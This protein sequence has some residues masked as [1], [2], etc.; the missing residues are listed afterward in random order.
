MVPQSIIVFGATGQ[1]GTDLVEVLRHENNFEV[2]A[3]SHQ[4]ADCTDREAVRRMFAQVRPDIVVNC[5]AFVRVDECEERVDDAFRVNAVG[6]FNVAKACAEIEALCVFISTDYVFD[7]AKDSAYG[8]SDA[9]NPI[10]VYGASKLAG[11][12]LTRQAARRCLIVRTASLFGKTGARGKGGNFVETIIKKAKAHEPIKVVNDITMSPTY[13]RDA[14]NGL[15][16]LLRNRATGLFHMAN[17][18]VCTWYALAKTISEF[19][20]LGNAIHPVSSSEL[21]LRA[22]RPKNSALITE[23]T[24]FQLP[25]WK[26]AL[27]AYLVEKGHLRYFS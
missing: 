12:Y 8:E 13:S 15:A 10:N 11:E 21:G 16:A 20:D 4:D 5:A 18:G 7:G 26:D 14:A 27:K 2:F 24:G 6:A 22:A 17:T 9:P 19:A 3:V 25:P 23:Q 1:L